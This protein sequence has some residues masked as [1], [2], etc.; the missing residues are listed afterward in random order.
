LELK[1]QR[2]SGASV[3]SFSSPIGERLLHVASINNSPT[4]PIQDQATA[5]PTVQ[6]SSANQH[7][8]NKPS[9]TLSPQHGAAME[10]NDSDV[11]LSSGIQQ[12]DLDSAAA[13]K[14]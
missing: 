5:Q 8:H 9:N 4:T 2:D 6:P 7:H 13:T 14:K 3:E 1:Q 12:W 11:D 10:N